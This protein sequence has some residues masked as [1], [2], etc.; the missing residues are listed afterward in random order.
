M[1]SVKTVQKS[2]PEVNKSQN[3]KSLLSGSGTIYGGDNDKSSADDNAL[4]RSSSSS[5]DIASSIDSGS[6]AVKRKGRGGNSQ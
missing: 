6:C 1:A 5:G 4:P 3:V 2:A